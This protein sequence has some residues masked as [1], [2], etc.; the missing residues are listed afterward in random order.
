[1][2]GTETSHKT[3]LSK[4]QVLWGFR[5]Q[6]GGPRMTSADGVAALSSGKSHVLALLQPVQGQGSSIGGSSYALVNGVL[7]SASG[8]VR[9]WA[10]GEKYTA[11][12]QLPPSGQLLRAVAVISA[13]DASFAILN[14]S[15]TSNR[16]GIVGWGPQLVGQA[17]EHV[18][19]TLRDVRQVATT[20]R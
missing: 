3:R 13:D 9:Q 5:T 10:V 17:L 1:M 12:Y 14:G 11:S 6:P 15:P 4:T 19:P 7:S 2:C 18:L 20:R 8:R 16:T